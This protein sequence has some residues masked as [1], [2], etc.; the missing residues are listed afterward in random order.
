MNNV[1]LNTLI[2][3]KI[4]YYFHEIGYLPKDSQ[5]FQNLKKNL[6]IE[7]LPQNITEKDIENSLTNILVYKYIC[8]HE[9]IIKGS[10]N[11]KNCI[12]KALIIAAD[13]GDSNAC[14]AISQFY[15]TITLNICYDI[16]ITKTYEELK[17]EFKQNSHIPYYKNMK[18]SNTY[19]NKKVKIFNN[20]NNPNLLWLNQNF[21]EK[22]YNK[23]ELKNINYLSAQ[24]DNIKKDILFTGNPDAELNYYIKYLSSKQDNDLKIKLIISSSRINFLKENP[25]FNIGSSNAQWILYNIMKKNID[26]SKYDIDS[27]DVKLQKLLL[28]SAIRFDQIENY[29]IFNKYSGSINALQ[30][31]YDKIKS[32]NCNKKYKKT[33]KTIE[34]FIKKSQ[35]KVK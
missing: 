35:T 16:D 25:E 27:S 29:N 22:K 10:E 5:L 18:I 20:G 1:D 26:L 8:M 28:K 19:I 17:S 3:S 21:N 31:Y 6:I 33:R 15:H 30:Y 14:Y 12:K 23:T 24:I 32:A 11:I 7:Q 4:Y 34:N 13:M 9:N 2:S